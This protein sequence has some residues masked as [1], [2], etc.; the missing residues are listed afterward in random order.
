MG[1]GG[2][3][4]ASDGAHVIPLPYL[5]PGGHL[6]RLSGQGGLCRG[7]NDTG[8]VPRT[9]GSERTH[10]GMAVLQD[11]R[12]SGRLGSSV[13]GRRRRHLIL[14]VGRGNAAILGARAC[15]DHADGRF[16]YRRE[17]LSGDP[18]DAALQVVL[19]CVRL[20]EDRRGEVEDDLW[21]RPGDELLCGAKKVGARAVMPRGGEPS[22]T[23][24]EHFS[25]RF[26]QEIGD[27]CPDEA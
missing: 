9:D 11:F 26:S 10:D 15:V 12:G 1:S 18:D 3:D 19:S 22:V 8:C 25:P 5:F 20:Q 6:E 4:P 7:G 16:L 17:E 23:D 2:D 24:G 13:G 21:S 27:P 14:G